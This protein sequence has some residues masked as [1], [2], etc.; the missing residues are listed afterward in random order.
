MKKL[1]LTL[2][3]FCFALIII[4][5]GSDD[6]ASNDILNDNLS[7]HVKIIGAWK[8]YLM[9]VGKDGKESPIQKG[10][11]DI[12]NLEFKTN[13]RLIRIV[14]DRDGGIYTYA[15]ST[16]TLDDDI[17]EIKRDNSKIFS[18]YRILLLDKKELKI[19]G[20]QGDPKIYYKR[21]K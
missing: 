5:C 3:V 21:I 17:L 4:G 18:T 15:D 11:D 1:H 14:E 10:V 12:E 8:P 13:G 7:N 20:L 16:Y 9:I 6:N 2:T 19:G